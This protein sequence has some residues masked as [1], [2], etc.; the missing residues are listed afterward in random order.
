[1]KLPNPLGLVAELADPVRRVQLI[2]GGIGLLAIVLAIAAGVH[3]F[4]RMRSDAAAYADCQ[5][6]AG[7][8]H[9]APADPA[10]CGAQ[11]VG[12]VTQARAA[13][14]CDQALGQADAGRFA[15]ENA[16]SAPVKRLVAQRDAATADVGDRDTTIDTLKAERSADV[17]RAETRGLAQAQ[18]NANATKVLNAAPRDD[19][20]RVRCDADCLSELA[21]GS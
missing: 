14:V 21:G 19:R 10:R 7:V 8:S 4:N 2:L 11:L 9:A 20:G 3:A 15:V 1:M 17:A 6:V 16:C 18:R 5:A 12:L 13:A